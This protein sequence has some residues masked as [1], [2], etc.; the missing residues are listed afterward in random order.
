MLNKIIIA[1]GITIMLIPTVFGAQ[2]NIIENFEQMHFDLTDNTK[3]VTAGD[4]NTEPVDGNFAVN[5]KDSQGFIARSNLMLLDSFTMSERVFIKDIKTEAVALSVSGKTGVI[6]SAATFKDGKIYSADNNAVGEYKAGQWITIKA[7]VIIDKAVVQN[8]TLY[9]NGT[10]SAKNVKIKGE[11]PFTAIK[12]LGGMQ[13]YVDDFTINDNSFVKQTELPEGIGTSVLGAKFE[14]VKDS[15][16]AEAV[17]VTTQLGIMKGTGDRVFEP[18]KEISRGELVAAI[19][20]A[21]KLN[22]YSSS[23]SVFSDVPPNYLYS[24]EIFCA[25]QAG[26]ISV[27][28][29][30]F[31]PDSVAEATQGIKMA[32]SALGY[33]SF[34]KAKGGYPVGYATM[35]MELK[36]YDEF[37]SSGIITR[38]D[39]AILIYNM[40]TADIA[41]TSSYGKDVSYN[42]THGRSLLTERFKLKEKRGV[43]TGNYITTFSNPN[44]SLPRGNIQIDGEIYGVDNDLPSGLLGYAVEFYYYDDTS[45]KH[46]ALVLPIRSKNVLKV[47][48]GDLIQRFEGNTLYCYFDKNS[49][50]IESIELNKNADIIYN[51]KVIIPDKLDS[52]L[53][54][55]LS[56]RVVL[57]DRDN[58]GIYDVVSIENYYDIVV[59]SVNEM[60][61][62]GKYGQLLDLSDTNSLY[63]VL[64]NGNPITL[65]SLLEW[66]VVTVLE[67]KLESGKKY[68]E[69][70]VCRKSFNAK[71]TGYG[72]ENGIEKVSLDNAF[73]TVSPQY[74]KDSTIRS[75]MPIGEYGTFYLNATGNVATFRQWNTQNGPPNYAYLIKAAAENANSLS[76]NYQVKLFLPNG[77]IKI[78]SMAKNVK[79]D[80]ITYK[81]TDIVKN[82]NI[83]TYQIIRYETNTNDEITLIDS[84]AVGQNEGDYSLKSVLNGSY[85]YSTNKDFY[86]FGRI[87][88]KTLIFVVPDDVNKDD[89]NRYAMKNV[90]IFL[91]DVTYSLSAYDRENIFAPLKVLL[92]KE[93]IITTPAK[94]TYKSFVLSSVSNAVDSS[95]VD[96]V[97]LS[98]Y[99]GNA[100]K[101]YIVGDDSI[102][103]VSN[104]PIRLNIGDVFR[105]TLTQQGKIDSLERII[106][107]DLSNIGSPLIYEANGTGVYYNG[108]PTSI[109]R[110]AYGT[111]TG[112]N[113]SS[114]SFVNKG[115]TTEYVHD[116]KTSG[117]VLVRANRDG[118]NDVIQCSINDLNVGDNIYFR[119]RYSAVF[120]V[121]IYR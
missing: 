5:L 108:A 81:K 6:F 32:V 118:K 55:N 85:T 29:S 100:Y 106:N 1:I 73:Y 21:A 65:K 3:W 98:G 46:I 97:K 48:Q 56:G 110:F 51:R 16:Y 37:P 80:G 10:I 109:N 103:Q 75:K 116:L 28:S 52:T 72:Y 11:A 20:E 79:I 47:V 93:S 40:L 107:S 12:L 102:L 82:N 7:E 13:G 89:D 101:Q 27:N 86:G 53:F 67:S 45:D 70:N 78:F 94:P 104:V 23:D 38:G 35:G 76:E 69:L 95:G 91:A 68:Y 17:Y 58:D 31:N 39:V 26:I 19:T 15:K 120:E 74:L 66:D 14:D 62:V 9:I 88:D 96:V 50:K 119:R 64:K 99:E 59:S 34:A 92:V 87:D 61:I 90:S 43:I 115:D 4:L 8:Y 25:A 49:N 71:V 33:D 60:Q 44:V 117:I 111:I 114:I 36:L 22:T 77:N 121:V 2:T 105:I 18:Y 30:L 83:P 84:S 113:G 24:K 41:L 42:T 54:L 57:I 63:D 112:I